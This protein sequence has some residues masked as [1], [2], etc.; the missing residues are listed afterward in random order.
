M[1]GVRARLA[2]ASSTLRG[3]AWISSRWR[4]PARTPTPACRLQTLAPIQGA[5]LDGSSA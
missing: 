1:A 4:E 3:P 5:S 2:P